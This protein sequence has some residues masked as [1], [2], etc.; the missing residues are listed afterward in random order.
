MTPRLREHPAYV[1]AGW[2]FYGFAKDS[3]YAAEGK[4]TLLAHAKAIIHGNFEFKHNIKEYHLSQRMWSIEE[5]VAD[6]MVDKTLKDCAAGAMEDQTD[7]LEELGWK[8]EP[9]PIHDN[10]AR[11]AFFIQHFHT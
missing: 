8:A 9:D 5:V 4:T 10:K 1:V 7:L 3:W 2:I 6:F 11:T